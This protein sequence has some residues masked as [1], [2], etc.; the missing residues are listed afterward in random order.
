VMTELP[1]FRV[2][3]QWS[4]VLDLF[5]WGLQWGIELI[6]DQSD[7]WPT[8]AGLGLSRVCWAHPVRFR[9]SV[10]ELRYGEELRD[11][12]DRASWDSRHSLWHHREARPVFLTGILP[13]RLRDKFLTMRHANV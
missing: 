11:W 5:R 13:D 7:L 3:P 8:P 1:E 2:N 9:E 6:L 10:D 4:V 12:L